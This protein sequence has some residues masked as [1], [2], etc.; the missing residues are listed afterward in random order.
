MSSYSST[1]TASGTYST[2][3]YSNGETYSSDTY[4]FSPLPDFKVSK[5][6]SRKKKMTKKEMLT[7]TNSRNRLISKLEASRNKNMTKKG[8]LV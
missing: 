3:T 2:E 8:K 5:E 4:T 6:S 1:Q 7:P